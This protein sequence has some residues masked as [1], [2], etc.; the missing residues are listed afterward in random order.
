MAAI[1]PVKRSLDPWSSESL[2]KSNGSPTGT[3]TPPRTHQNRVSASSVVTPSV[4]G[5]S[6]S[7]STTAT[8][9]VLPALP[10]A[11]GPRPGQVQYL[12][13][14]SHEP[15]RFTASGL[16]DGLRVDR[17]TGL[18]CGTPNETG[19]FT[20]TTTVGSTS[21]DDGTFTVR[22]AG[23][24]LT[25]NNQGMTGQFARQSVTGDCTVTARLVS[26]TGGS[27]R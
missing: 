11:L 10:F 6:V 13:R 9:R 21:Y 25:V 20:I 19:E 4:T 7:T 16:P 8:V 5:A 3:R 27:K 14:A 22:G 12:L 23:V 2:P 24:D 15:I 1:D 17:R 18:I 26:R